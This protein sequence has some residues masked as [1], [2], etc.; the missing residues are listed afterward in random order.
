MFLMSFHSI[1]VTRNT[2]YYFIRDERLHIINV[3]CNVIRKKR[4]THTMQSTRHAC[5][6]VVCVCVCQVREE[7]DTA[8]RQ[9]YCII[10]IWMG[11]LILVHYIAWT[12]LIRTHTYTHVFVA[13]MR[14]VVNQ[15]FDVSEYEINAY[16]AT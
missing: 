13:Y 4:H 3:S 5:E 1:C 11:V 14:I 15:T 16:I 7:R 12:T 10:P 2:L 8:L 9:C 6:C